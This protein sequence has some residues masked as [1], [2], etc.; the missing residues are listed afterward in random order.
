[1]QVQAALIQLIQNARAAMDSG[2]T[3]TMETTRP[4]DKLLRLRVSDTGHGIK[5][6]QLS[7]IFDPFFTTKAVGKGTGL[8]LSLA[9]GIVQKHR[10][11]IEVD[12]ALG[13]G[14]TFRITLPVRRAASE[15][16]I[17]KEE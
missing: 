3:L 11:K 4:D 5:P 13:R 16:A 17:P 6:E 15:P 10:G 8:G 9:Y 2:G 12:T 7:R 14:T 1:L